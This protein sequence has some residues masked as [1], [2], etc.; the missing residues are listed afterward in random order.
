MTDVTVFTWKDTVCMFYFLVY[1][2][3]FSHC[4]RTSRTTAYIFKICIC[5]HSIS[6]LRSYSEGERHFLWICPIVLLWHKDI[7]KLK[8]LCVFFENHCS[9]K[10]GLLLQFYWVSESW[11]F[12]TI[13]SSREKMQTVSHSW[14]IVL[15]S[16]VIKEAGSYVAPSR[17]DLEDGMWWKTPG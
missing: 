7:Y 4:H 5:V 10:G 3:D 6:S 14:Q 17:K 16:T 15:E 2:C 12:K 9:S 8:A 11:A 13:L 1:I